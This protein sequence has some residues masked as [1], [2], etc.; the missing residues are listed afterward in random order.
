MIKRPYLMGI[1]IAV[2]ISSIFL[3]GTK[4]DSQ[5]S[6]QSKASHAEREWRTSGHA[7]KTAEAFIHWD[8]DGEVPTSCA[9]CHSTPGFR[10]YIGADGSTVDVVNSPAPLGTTVECEA[11]HADPERGIP[12]DRTYVIFPSGAVVHDLGPEAMCMTCHQGRAST[13]TVD[14]EIADSGVADEDEVSSELGFINIHYFPSAAN[15]FGT[16][17]KGGYEYAGQSYDARFAHIPGYNACNTCH[18]PHSLE[19]DL[20]ACNTCHIVDDPK[21]IRFIGSQVDYDGDGNLL[22]GIFYEIESFKDRLYATIQRYAR[23]VIGVPIAY[24]EISYPYFFTDTNGNGIVD[25]EE[26][27]SDNRYSSFTAR[28]LK[29]CYNFQLA[30]KEPNAY[31]HGGKYVIELLYDSIADLGVKL[32]NGEVHSDLTMIRFDR[33]RTPIAG[34]GKDHDKLF[35]APPVSLGIEPADSESQTGQG[36]LLRTDEG[37][38]DGSAEAFRHW[39]E[40]GEVSSSCAKCH[41][42][43]GLPYFIE[44]GKTVASHI[45]NG[46]L[47]ST[48]H[49][50]PPH[51][52]YVAQ[53]KFPSGVSKDMGDSS[54]LCLNC[55]QGRASKYTVDSEIAS[56]PGPYRF[57]NIHYFAS[58]ASLFGSEVHGGYEFEAKSY[59]GR[60]YYSNHN[61]LFDTC[62]ECHMGTLSPNRARDNSDDLFHNVQHPNPADCVLCHGQDISQP[63]P[64][65]DPT[66]FEFS[67]IRPATVPDYD[68]D[69]NKTESLQDEIYGLEQ[70]L[71]AQ[72]QVYGKKIGKPI[73]YDAL[74][75]PYFFN[76]TNGN[77]VADPEELDS[78][79]GYEFNAPMLRAAYNFQ[80]SK[81]EPCGYIHNSRYIA[82]LLVDS[83]GHLGGNVK[84][85]TWR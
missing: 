44:N 11:C 48:C 72:L 35:G 29:A 30:K 58:A 15:Q 41:S 82:Q 62:V 23:E 19:V 70:A 32:N 67:G 5:V 75:Y 36:G 17:A 56:G 85:Y 60:K 4:A 38:F 39:D 83:I 26:A 78:D 54:N 46:L 81:K 57:I 22:E 61:G 12:N 37:H 71:Y 49:T 45:S 84:P 20:D 42:A 50:V 34:G 69:K 79:N 59:A 8:E 27:D 74:S 7:D 73:V 18:N 63:H 14:A 1:L 24:D 68:G 40:D 10:D 77:G 25:P 65:A 53:V 13:K 21:D 9:K 31:A 80:M 33:D 6:I 55:H 52:R 47:C 66:R 64:G 16:M 2:F 28:L 76:D 43:E 3:A 51:T